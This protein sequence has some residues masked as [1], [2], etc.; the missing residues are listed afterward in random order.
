MQAAAYARFSS[1]NQRAESVDAQL[2]GI[3]AWAAANQTAH[4]CRLQR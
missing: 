2:Y 4:T 1:D 3:K